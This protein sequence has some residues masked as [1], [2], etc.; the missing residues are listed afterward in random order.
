MSYTLLKIIMRELEV[1]GID[2]EGV[3]P[4]RVL[5]DINLPEIQRFHGEMWWIKRIVE[6]R[7]LVY[8]RNGVRCGYYGVG[9]SFALQGEEEQTIGEI[10]V[11]ADKER[12]IIAEVPGTNILNRNQIIKS[13]DGKM[14]I[15]PVGGE[16]IER[17][18]DINVAPEGLDAL[19]MNLA[20]FL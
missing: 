20:L 14:R 19:N 2:L 8:S 12:R 18:L 7:A 16:V 4:E 15:Q 1:R 3:A 11:T 10:F 5:K 17:A 13:S 6:Q 9:Y